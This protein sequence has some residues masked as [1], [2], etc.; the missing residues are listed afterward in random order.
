MSSLVKL[1]VPPFAPASPTSLTALHRPLVQADST[2]CEAHCSPCPT[3]EAAHQAEI[4]A[5]QKLSADL[6]LR[7]SQ[8]VEDA[9][10]THIARL[11]AQQI[12]LVQT[13]LTAVLPHLADT[14]L[15]HALSDV[16]AEALD[17]LKQVTLH[18]TKHP[19]L[20]LGPLAKDASL[21]IEDDPTH[22]RHSLSLREGEGLTTLDAAP[23]I[24][25]CLAR[26]TGLTETSPTGATPL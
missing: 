18:L 5:A 2:R 3:C 4:A 6:G 1:H 17:P 8:L 9:I 14:N 24:E 10:S 12:E 11:E 19:E 20:D 15:R 13:V 25:A 7:L 22:P 26:L 16:I 21:K 23:L